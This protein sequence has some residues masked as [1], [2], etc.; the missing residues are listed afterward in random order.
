MPT[1]MVKSAGACGRPSDSTYSQVSSLRVF[2]K[3]PNLSKMAACHGAATVMG[4]GVAKGAG[5]MAII[6]FAC[7]MRCRRD[8]AK[9]RSSAL[10]SAIGTVATPPSCSSMVTRSSRTV[11][12]VPS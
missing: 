5:A 11:S 8:C 2:T 9:A 4:F 1:I 3:G 10:R 6:W 7:S 12:S